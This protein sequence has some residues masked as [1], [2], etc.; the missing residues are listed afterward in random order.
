MRPEERE[1]MKQFYVK[2]L[3]TPTTPTDIKKTPSRKI[4]HSWEPWQS[5]NL[6]MC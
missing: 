1:K 6:I 4:L 5:L 2:E 3:L